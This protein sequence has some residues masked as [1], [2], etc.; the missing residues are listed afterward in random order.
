MADFTDPDTWDITH[1]YFGGTPSSGLEFLGQQGVELN[2]W[3]GGAYAALY[4]VNWDANFQVPAVTSSAS[5]SLSAFLIQDCIDPAGDVDTSDYW[6]YFAFTEQGPNTGYIYFL[7]GDSEDLDIAYYE[8]PGGAVFH[9]DVAAE[10]GVAYVAY[11]Q[12]SM[13]KC[14]KSTNQ[15]LSWQSMGTITNEGT[16][17]QLVILDDGTVYCYYLDDGEIIK[18][19]SDDQGT[20][21]SV[22]GGLENNPAVI[23]VENPYVAIEEAVVWTGYTGDGEENADIYTQVFIPTTGI[24][25]SDIVLVGTGTVKSTITNTG[26]ELLT[27]FDWE[28]EVEGISP[29]GEFFG[30][31]ALFMSLFRGRVFSGSMTTEDVIRLRTGESLDISTNAFFGI[32]HVMVTARVLKDEEVLAEK[33]ED[34][35]LLGGRILLIYPEE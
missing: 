7:D 16:D 35:F 17:P 31:S 15:G 23:D 24:M 25:M 30:G 19:I 3:E 14:L 13:I 22:E 29:L 33:S 21:W 9:P 2:A 32:G 10:D 18:T 20:S 28:I 12:N 6:N 5:S 34:G 26:T 1:W 4:M 8:I 11:E 27:Y